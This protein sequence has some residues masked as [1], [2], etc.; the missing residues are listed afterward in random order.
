MVE[1]GK[2]GTG[3][4]N[5]FIWSSISDSFIQKQFF[6]WIDMVLK[7]CHLGHALLM[8]TGRQHTVYPSFE[9]HRAAVE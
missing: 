6:V 8:L 3:Q 9:A 5:S 1:L 2:Q 4:V 7:L